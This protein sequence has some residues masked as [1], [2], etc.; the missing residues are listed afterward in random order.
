MIR[1]AL[2]NKGRLRAP[3]LRLLARIGL[4]VPED[5]NGDRGLTVVTADR[6]YQLL[7]VNARDV[8]TCLE[9]GAADVAITG[10]DLVEEAGLRFPVVE[11]LGFGRAR[12]VLAVPDRSPV[13]GTDDLPEGARVATAHPRI[14]R[15]H[16]DELGR[17]VTL[18]PL[19]GAVEAAPSI[20]IADAIVDLTETGVT[21][22]SNGL[23][24]VAKILDVEAAA[25]VRAEADAPQRERI[26][27][28]LLAL[29][30][31]VRAER[32]RY[33]MA[34]VPSTLLPE[35]SSLLPGVGGPTVLRL[36]GRDDWIA[37]HAVVDASAINGI[38]AVLKARGA[39]GILVTPLER[40]VVG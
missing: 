38:V 12:L 18:V 33:L 40:M 13:A 3:A 19:S 9:L 37:I 29:R 21:L 35:L 16:F 39:T 11:R 26:D 15:R 32:S 6:R 22:R 36:L 23:R 28:L 14:A 5:G 8:P 10:T 20:G 1:I 24:E 34:N 25:F 30:S 2:P 31:V 7:S 17:H 27:E 4:S